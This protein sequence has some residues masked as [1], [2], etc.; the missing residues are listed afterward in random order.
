VNPLPRLTADMPEEPIVYV[1]LEM[2]LFKKPLFT[3]MASTVVVLLTVNGALYT[4]D[5][6][7]GAVPFVV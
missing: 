7:V 6:V 4:A 5:A 2:L 1:A 3:A